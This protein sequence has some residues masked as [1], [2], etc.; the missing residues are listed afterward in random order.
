M[1]E[2]NRFSS[3]DAPEWAYYAKGRIDGE[4]TGEFVPILYRP[5]EWEAVFEDTIWLNDKNE[6][7]SLEGWDA[8]YLRILT[9]ATFKHKQTGN[10]INVFNTHLDHVGEMARAG[11]AEVIVQKIQEINKWPSFLCGDL[12][13]EPKGEPYNILTKH[14][15]NSAKHTTPFNHFGHVKSTVT[16]FE[17][18][19]L[20]AGGQ[21][22]DYIFAPS[23]T[24]K[25]TH[26]VNCADT[27]K[28]SKDPADKL[29][30]RL[31]QFGML[32]SK[33]NGVYMSDHRPLVADFSLSGK[34]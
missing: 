13:N 14:L 20:S 33:Y 1:D 15:I 18:E 19:V 31:D 4:D 5:S 23:Y 17:G 34:C 10:Y 22:I 6:R 28:Y 27:D 32:H 25:V 9:F 24:K 16:G 3:K 11:S 7:M 12:N 21:N 30:L 2:L 26:N 29:L 8:K